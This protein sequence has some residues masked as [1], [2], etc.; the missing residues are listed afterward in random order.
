MIRI[1]PSFLLVVAAALFAGE[2]ASA[3]QFDAQQQK[4][5]DELREARDLNDVRAMERIVERNHDV[6]AGIYEV[7][8]TQTAYSDSI[9][10][11]EEIKELA[12]L[13]DQAENTN[14]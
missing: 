9:D 3:Q 6:V 13:L 1:P 7:L 8:E 11:W 2:R 14:A 12:R 5:L 10:L 4:V